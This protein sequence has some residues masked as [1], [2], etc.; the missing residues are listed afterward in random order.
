MAG[1]SSGVGSGLDGAFD[2]MTSLAGKMANV[3]APHIGALSADAV[4]RHICA[5][6]AI[7]DEADEAD[8]RK[9]LEELRDFLRRGLVAYV[10]AEKAQEVAARCIEEGPSPS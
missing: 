10:G 8:R 2:P 3:L 7:D 4:A 9:K 6:Y 1:I 5:K